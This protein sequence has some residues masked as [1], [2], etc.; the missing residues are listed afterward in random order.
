MSSVTIAR[1]G[2]TMGQGA[3]R[4]SQR[5]PP[6]LVQRRAQL[7]RCWRDRLDRVTRLSLAYYEAEQLATNGAPPARRRAVRRAR[8]LARRA[9]NE[10]LALAEI[11]AALDRIARGH[12]GACEQCREPISAAVLARQPQARF[13]AACRGSVTG[14]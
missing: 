4:T 6:G 13:C 2:P 7:E 3:G 9:I 11:E 1:P 5:R 8:Q 12:Y 10:R 14:S